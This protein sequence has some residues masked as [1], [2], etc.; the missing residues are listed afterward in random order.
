MFGNAYTTNIKSLDTLL[1]FN[2]YIVTIVM[3]E[4]GKVCVCGLG[5]VL[6]L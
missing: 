3:E 4:I 5:L 6:E 2:Y 1:K